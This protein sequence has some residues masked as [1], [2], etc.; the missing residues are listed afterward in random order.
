MLP[1]FS[2]ANN[3]VE[4]IRG[5]APKTFA[6]Q[7]QKNDTK[8]VTED[9]CDIT[10][11]P[12]EQ[13]FET[14][15]VNGFPSCWNRHYSFSSTPQHP[16]VASS[17]GSRVMQFTA[18][19]ANS[20]SMAV[21]PLL[22]ADISSLQLSFSYQ[23]N[24]FNDAQFEIGVISN[25]TDSTTFKSLQT[26]SLV[27]YNWTEQIISFDDY[28]GSEKYIAFKWT[29]TSKAPASRIIYLDNIKIKTLSACAEPANIVISNIGAKSALLKWNE[30]QSIPLD[31]EIEVVDN[32]SVSAI[33]EAVTG[34]SFVMKGL[35]PNTNYTVKVRANCGAKGYS[36]WV[37]KTFKTNDNAQDCAAPNMFKAE[38]ITLTDALLTWAEEGL[39]DQYE[40]QYKSAD[41]YVW[42]PVITVNN[43]EYQLTGLT[44]STKYN[45][46]IRPVCVDE[47][48]IAWTEISFT[49]VCEPVTVLPFIEN[50]NTTPG[51]NGNNGLLPTCWSLIDVT[52]MNNPFVSTT[53][54]SSPN[55][56]YHSAFGAL[57]IYQSRMAILPA[58]DIEASGSSLKDLQVGFWAKPANP[59]GSVVLGVMTDPTERSTFAAVETLTFTDS[60]WTECK[61]KLEN[62]KGDG[63]Y[64]ALLWQS[65]SGSTVLIDDIY[66]D[67][68]P[69]C[70]PLD[71]VF[72]S[73]TT[74]SVKLQWDK[75]SISEFQILC[76][77]YNTTSNWHNALSVYND[78]VTITNLFSN[79]KY[80]LYIRKVCP[81]GTGYSLPYVTTFTTGCGDI[82]G[83]ML[84]YADFFDTYGV[85]A[86][87]LGIFPPCWTKSSTSA[88]YISTVSP[89]TLGA[90]LFR[91]SSSD[92]AMAVMPKIDVDIQMLKVDFKLSCSNLASI[93]EVGIWDNND[94]TLVNSIQVKKTNT[95]ED[96]IVYF[97]TTSKTSGSIAFRT[98]SNGG[99]NIDEVI[100]DYIPSCPTPNNLKVT[101]VLKDEAT[102]EWTENGNAQNWVISY[103]PSGY[104]PDDAKMHILNTNTNPTMLWLLTP[105]TSYDV[106]VQAGC[107]EEWSEKLTF[108]TITDIAGIPYIT[109]FEDEEEIDNWMLLN[110]TQTNKWHI[111][112]AVNYNSGGSNAL[113]ISNDNGVNNA[114]SRTTSYVYA[115]RTLNFTETGEYDLSLFWRGK[116]DYQ[117]DLSRIFLVPANITIE[118]GN[119]YGMINTQNGTPEGWLD[120]GGGRLYGQAKWQL[121]SREFYVPAAGTYNLVFYWK[122]SGP[123][124]PQ[125]PPIAIDDIVVRKKTCPT[126]ANID[127]TA[128]ASDAV[129][130]W[131]KTGVAE[132]WEIQYDYQDFILGTGNQT[133]ANTSPSITI[134][135]LLPEKFYDVYVRAICGV[136]DTSRWVKSFFATQ[137]DAITTL[138]YIENF[139]NTPLAGEGKLPLCWDRYSSNGLNYPFV[140]GDAVNLSLS[141]IE[142]NI[143]NTGYNMVIL[144]PIA[145][146]SI[147]NLQITFD[148]FSNDVP[149]A[150]VFTLGVLEDP[151]SPDDFVPMYNIEI[152][153]PRFWGYNIF[154]FYQYKGD[155]QY[156]AFKWEGA[157]GHTCMI[158]NINVAIS[159]FDPSDTCARPLAINISE[160]S[161][162]TAKVSWSAGGTES[163][164]SLECK[165]ASDA[166]YGTPIICNTPNY[167][168]NTLTPETSYAVRVKSICRE[169]QQ[170]E[171]IT[172]NFS[173]MAVRPTY[174]ITPSAGPNGVISPD[175]EV[176]VSEGDNAPFTFTPD[177]QYKVKRVLVDG[178]S[179]GNGTTYTFTNV[180]SNATIRVEFDKIDSTNI[181]QYLLDK[182]VAIYPN[183]T[184]D[185]LYV[186][187]ET[188]FEQIEITNLLGQIIY[189]AKIDSQELIIDATNYRSGIYFIRLE[190][191]QGVVTKKFV[192]E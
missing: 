65:P 3:I 20:F 117:Y 101:S 29:C 22:D 175:T 183:P 174:T 112:N 4:D 140:G 124:T 16:Y 180:R 142:F 132:E 163:Q 30:S 164:W 39:S 153:T 114:F 23:T 93:F 56:N 177:A 32:N 190:G 108:S 85:G 58:I 79:T 109:N 127:A 181:A 37:T 122:N 6:S 72:L 157:N 147:K 133:F 9:D 107:G 156:I 59:A 141:Y 128:T 63:Q 53:I 94:F 43:T 110:G 111:D 46:R 113:Y 42:E 17:G 103:G 55:P 62:Y 19:A 66:I 24:N 99:C 118:A 159:T 139:E 57:S 54:T 184:Q 73:A 92:Y 145:A 89:F 169:D 185:R 162:T 34:T 106:Y 135:G 91:P 88:P 27:Q 166:D 144:P 178:D 155:G 119:H 47:T 26:L 14:T 188:L 31:Y 149:S 116:G 69:G 38:D 86:P 170:S 150:G 18:Q 84:P 105:K 2:T 50:F 70:T 125:Q 123:Y 1:L 126:P 182:A 137:C 52:A 60:Q 83:S 68:A 191:K 36:D 51:G 12:Y 102:I 187:M 134:A 78:T 129:L 13:D 173:T 90:M 75:Q 97:N 192:K 25:P 15:N 77:P 186:K 146:D 80:S 96:H 160:I 179:V 98:N 76:I 67:I 120:I 87:T 49:T 176:T 165:L 151:N 81:L 131:S 5:V 148:A 71:T 171:P 152:T 74:N 8:A 61:V 41:A 64:I 100:V 158:D 130:T 172:I 82:T 40:I 143:A 33:S 44:S 154:H 115:T 21:T 10:V 167:T 138:P 168:L 136:G 45:V 161:E 95:A 48:F 35:E 189:V 121:L 28:D 11:F 7:I 104:E